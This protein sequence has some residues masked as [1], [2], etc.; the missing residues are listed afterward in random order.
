[1]GAASGFRGLGRARDCSLIW[2]PF[3]GLGLRILARRAFFSASL[4]SCL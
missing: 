1:M 4:L 2:E 3:L